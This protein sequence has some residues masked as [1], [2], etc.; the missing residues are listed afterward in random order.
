MRHIDIVPVCWFSMGQRLPSIGVLSDRYRLFPFG[1]AADASGDD[2]DLDFYC[3]G[4]RHIPATSIR[5]KRH[6]HTLDRRLVRK[7]GFLA[8]GIQVLA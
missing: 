6:R 4:R 2:L 8:T 7:L 5:R 3:N 1:G